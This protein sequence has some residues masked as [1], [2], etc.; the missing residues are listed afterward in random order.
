LIWYCIYGEAVVFYPKLLAMKQYM[1]PGMVVFATM[2]LS[3]NSETAKEGNKEAEVAMPMEVAYKGKPAIGSDENTIKVMNWNKWLSSGKLDS[4]FTL[5]ADSVT[6]RLKD[7]DEFNTTAD[8]AK[9]TIQAYFSA[10]SSANIQYVAVLPVDV[11]LSADKTDQWVLS[12]TDESYLMKNGSRDHNIIHEDYRL[13]NGK[14]REINQYGRIVR[15][16]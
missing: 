3:C 10:I 12:W 8:S 6:I 1:L 14:I 2:L 7:G 13:V 11:K 15:E 16:K 5:L 4:A 9:K